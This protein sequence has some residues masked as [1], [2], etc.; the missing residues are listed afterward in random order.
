MKDAEIM[1]TL[2]QPSIGGIEETAA[3]RSIVEGTATQ[4]GEQFFAS[5]VENLAKVLGTHGAWVTEYLEEPRRLRALA[6][7]LRG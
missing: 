7:W 5:L 3:L 2:T 6:L 1:E 4:T